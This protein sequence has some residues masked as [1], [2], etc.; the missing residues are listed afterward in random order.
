M[1]LTAEQSL[2]TEPQA[3]RKALTLLRKTFFLYRCPIFT[4]TQGSLLDAFI[5]ITEQ[6]WDL[7]DEHG[8]S[9]CALP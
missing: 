3:F 4:F 2:S 6:G 5:I 1:C 7:Q 8:V 9:L